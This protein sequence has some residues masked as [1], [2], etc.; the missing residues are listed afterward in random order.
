MAKD[1]M[2]ITVFLGILVFL[3]IF[4][5][6]YMAKVFTGKRTMLSFIIRPLEISLYKICGI[7]ETRMMS[8]KQYSIA[9]ILF[10]I[11]GLIVLFL[12]QILQGRLP[13]NP[14][15]FGPVRWDTALNTSISF[16]T[17]TNWQAYGGETTMSYFTQM[18]GLTVQNFVSAAIGMAV[19]LPLIRAFT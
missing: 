15:G 11:T 1:I 19:L 3:A 12:L 18:A 10:N 14:M 13:L 6:N 8:W 9:F 2:Y 7:D 4:L 16:V 5:G 17:N